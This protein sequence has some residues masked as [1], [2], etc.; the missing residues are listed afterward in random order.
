MKFATIRRVRASLWPDAEQLP[1]DGL[2]YRFRGQVC[3][4]EEPISTAPARS[5]SAAF[6]DS[7]GRRTV[8]S[9]AV[10]QRRRQSER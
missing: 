3:I 2:E 10:T 9:P 7:S 6:P 5:L 8:V 1:R 4:T